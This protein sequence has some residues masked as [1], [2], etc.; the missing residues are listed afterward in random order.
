MEGSPRRHLSKSTAPI[1]PQP[2]HVGVA[3]NLRMEMVQEN[4][5][6]HSLPSG[7]G[8]DGHLP[9]HHKETESVHRGC[10]ITMVQSRQAV[11]CGQ[12]LTRNLQDCI[13]STR[14]ARTTSLWNI[15]GGTPGVGL[16]LAVGAYV[17]CRRDQLGGT[18]NTGQIASGSDRRVLHNATV[19]E[20][21]LSRI[22]THMPERQREDCWVIQGGNVSHK[23]IQRRAPGAYGHTSPPCQR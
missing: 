4:E 16:Q 8:G 21:L 22:Y 20:Y 9:T 3:Q 12:S 19:P 17:N 2:I 7:P 1:L 23:C 18:G 10:D 15:L 13:D 5:R 6:T 11:L 14:G